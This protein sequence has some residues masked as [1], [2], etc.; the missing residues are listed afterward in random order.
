MLSLVSQGFEATLNEPLD[1][2]AIDD[3]EMEAGLEAASLSLFRQPNGGVF[4]TNIGPLQRW[5][6][7]R[8]INSR[9][10]LLEKMGIDHQLDAAVAY[11]VL[12]AG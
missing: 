3:S 2:E 12:H 11:L 1:Y 4:V 8:M 6:L 9:R 5:W 7:Y 10:Q